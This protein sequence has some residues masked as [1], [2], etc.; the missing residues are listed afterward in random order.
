MTSVVPTTAEGT[1]SAGGRQS[2]LRRLLR[3]PV[4]VVCLA[5]L[6]VVLAVAIIAPIL[7]P[8]VATQHAG[9]LAAAGQGPSAE[10]P[11]GTDLLGRDVL[12]RLLVGTRI[13]VIAVVEAVVVVTVLG[14]PLGLCAGY[15][16]GRVDRAINWSGDLV[17]ALPGIAM[18]LVVLAVFPGSTTAAMVSFGLLVAPTMMR[19]VR[20]ATLPLR[21]EPYVAAARVSGLSHPRILAR[22]LLPRL[23]GVVIVQCALIAGTALIAL[24]GLAFLGFVAPAPAPSWGG[25]VGDGAMALVQQPWLIW[26][27]GI[28]IF[29]T[30]LAFGMLGDALRDITASTWSPAQQTTRKRKAPKPATTPT[31][32]PTVTSD[33]VE[34][35]SE[36]LLRVEELTVT[37]HG[38][39]APRKVLDGV[40]FEIRPGEAV[41]MVG[42]SGCGKSMSA[43]A[44]LGLLPPVAQ[45]ESGRVWF[46]GHDLAGLSEADLRSVRGK[47]IGFISQEPMV[48]LNPAYSVG[49]QLAE[50]VRRHHDV[51]RSEAR[52]RVEELLRRV[53]LPDPAGAATRYPHELSGGMAQRVS[54]ARALAGSPALLIADEPTTALDVTVQGGILDLFRELQEDGMALLFVTHDW[55][56]VADICDRAIVMYAGEVVERAELSEIVRTPRHPYTAA[57]LRSDPHRATRRRRLPTITGTVPQP[58]EWPSGC[59]F[60]PRCPLAT[61]ECRMAAVPLLQIQPARESRC[62]H[63]D[64]LEESL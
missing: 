30:V 64:Q 1:T 34:Q 2:V 3:S 8:N 28:V 41:G 43:L 42:E 15:F 48:S 36:P 18:L 25:M 47:R 22:H 29:L 10:H 58:G 16:G 12:D 51:S 63:V 50:V 33:A 59:R 49:T 40:N 4:A 37:L 26:P 23:G 60:S 38:P 39:A 20:S 54:I 13:T 46:E 19:V 61:E 27:P 31:T 56:V 32:A 11:L 5:Y 14:V 17:L 7:L 52:Q 9:D 57:L 44:I 21:Q 53:H 62:I 45:V 35:S 6:A 24:S 55:G